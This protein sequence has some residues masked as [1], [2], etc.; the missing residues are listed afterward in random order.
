MSLVLIILSFLS[1]NSSN[2]LGILVLASATSLTIV[3][4]LIPSWRCRHFI[5]NRWLAWTGDSRTG[6]DIS[7]APYCGDEKLWR[8]MLKNLKRSAIKS[9][10]SDWY[11]WRL[12]PAGGIPEDPTDILR[13][14]K[15]E[16]LLGEE[17]AVLEGEKF[18]A[19][20]FDDGAATTRVSLLWGGAQNFR[21]RVSRA[22]SSMPST[23]LKSKPFSK[24]GYAGEGLCLA[25]GILGRNKG[26]NPKQFVFVPSNLP[27]GYM[28]DTSTWEP[29]P[30]KVMRSCYMEVMEAQYGGLGK[31]YVHATVELSLILV[32]CPPDAI[33][34]WLVA[35]LEQQYLT[36]NVEIRQM[37]GVMS[38]EL[39]AH[40]R[41][42]YT[43]MILSLNYMTNWN[44][45]SEL[46]RP[47]LICTGI[48]LMAENKAKPEWWD[49]SEMRERRRKEDA[50]LGFGWRQAALCLLGMGKEQVETIGG[51]DNLWCFD[52]VGI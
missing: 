20:I 26:L 14:A 2:S 16:M 17:K 32:D 30:A 34:A 52:G 3:Q 18:P 29:R 51:Q 45:Q 33:T 1:G 41:S 8:S 21:R 36:L 5:A 40:Y 6:I 39:N 49:V 44:S 48:L 50:A 19:S 43:S 35:G 27:P 28:E 13:H 11:G 37:R 46:A 38:H 7:D 4:Y 24:D 25:M 10:P 9:T 47:D 15:Q 12:F 42:S 22:T 31:P 23:L